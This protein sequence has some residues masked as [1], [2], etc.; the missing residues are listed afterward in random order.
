MNR[1]ANSAQ[2]AARN[3]T[4]RSI[5]YRADW[6]RAEAGARSHV[7]GVLDQLRR[8]HGIAG[9]DV[10][11]LGC[12]IGT[13]LQLFLADNRVRGV[14]GLPEAVLEARQRGI[15]TLQADLEDPLALPDASADWI[16]CID[17]LEHLQRP[18]R[19]LAEAQRILRDG[20]RLV[21]NVPNHFDWRGR[22]HIL[23]GSGIDSQGY[24]P[25]SAAWEY[26]HLRFFQHASI[27]ALL[28]AAGFGIE[29]DCSSRVSSLPGARRL[30]ALGGEPALAW[31]HAQWP[32]LFCAGFF[33]V[34]RK[35]PT[36]P[37]DGA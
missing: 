9:Q 23:L 28:A 34:C 36:H 33:L 31:L 1:N 21:I 22:L 3:T 32:D 18:A 10:V 2:N 15:D 7:T 17:V 29:E 5:D 30:A 13:N 8:Q 19:C 6:L 14:E 12:G 26:P 20:G 24:F 16:L 37:D 27:I 4:A 25:G 35:A 11:E